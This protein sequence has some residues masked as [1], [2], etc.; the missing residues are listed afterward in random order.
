M[1]IEG[2]AASIQV[3]VTFDEAF[4]GAEYS[5]TGGD[6]SYTGTVPDGLVVIQKV[7]SYN[8]TYTVKSTANSQEYTSTVATGQ[9]AGEYATELY[10]FTH[11]SGHGYGVSSGGG[12]AQSS[13]V[14]GERI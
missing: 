10:T 5:I 14:R 9:Y 12:G 4:K 13:Q 1:T 3:K 6:E 8:T 7:K 11:D 2:G